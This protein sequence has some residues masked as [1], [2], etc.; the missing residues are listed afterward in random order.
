M[1]FEKIDVKKKND[2]NWLI[3]YKFLCF[4]GE[5]KVMY[6]GRDKSEC[7]TN[8]FFDMEFNRLD[9]HFKDPNSN[10]QWQKPSEFEKMKKIAKT[11]SKNTKFLRVDFYFMNNHVYVGELTFFQNAGLSPVSSDYWN[12]KFSSWIDIS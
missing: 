5:P 2:D 3:D 1:T 9:L 8:D 12:K 6:L 11:L 4:N 7:P 10:I